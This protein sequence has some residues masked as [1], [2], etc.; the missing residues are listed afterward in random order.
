MKKTS[1]CVLIMLLFF[2][3]VSIPQIAVVKA[4]DP[5][6]IREDGSVEGTDKIHRNGNVYSFTGNVVNQTVVI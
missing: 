3:V 2:V 4:Q 6:Y 5:I 1:S